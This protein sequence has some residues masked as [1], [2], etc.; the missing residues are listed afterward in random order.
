M[1]AL[2][3]VALSASAASAKSSFEWFTGGTLLAAG[4]QRTFELS[5]GPPRPIHVHVVV[6]PVLVLVLVGRVRSGPRAAIFGGR[7]GTGEETIEF[8]EATVAQ[9]A[10]CAISGAKITT[11]PLEN[12]I[13]EGQNGEVL[14][15]FGP[16]TGTTF[17][18]FKFLDKPGEECVL[19][20]TT[21]GFTGNILGL[22]SSQK[23]EV[24]RGDIKFEAGPKNT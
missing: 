15:L 14:I 4:Q 7:P 9:P 16:K 21:T 22:P 11:A 10:G 20:G 6:G 3:V 2:S 19:N 12:E 23:T 13:V 5:G 24:L 8:E 18:T 1:A 17:S